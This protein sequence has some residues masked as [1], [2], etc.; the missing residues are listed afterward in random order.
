[1]G[2]AFSS[3]FAEAPLGLKS[4]SFE[5][6][7]SKRGDRHGPMDPAGLLRA[8]RRRRVSHYFFLGGIAIFVSEGAGA[9]TFGFSFFGFLASLLLRT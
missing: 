5:G 1:M 4:I 9:A 8:C 6:E 7:I 3:V 2:R